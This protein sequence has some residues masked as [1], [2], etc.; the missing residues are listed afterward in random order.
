LRGLDV[1]V[2]KEHTTPSIFLEDVRMVW[3]HLR[4]QLESSSDL[5][6]VWF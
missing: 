2:P 6:E 1:Q 3:L 4:M 5:S